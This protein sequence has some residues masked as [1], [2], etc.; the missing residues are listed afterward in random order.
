[1][2]NQINNT[3]G[4]ISSEKCQHSNKGN[5]IT[6]YQTKLK[7]LSSDTSKPEDTVAVY[8]HPLRALVT[9]NGWKREL[10]AIISFQI[11]LTQ[12]FEMIREKQN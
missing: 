6:N 7:R 3:I 11:L 1:M 5:I 9:T 4:A 2:L 10:K 12:A 8:S